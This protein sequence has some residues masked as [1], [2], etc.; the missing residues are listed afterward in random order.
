MTFGFVPE[1]EAPQGRSDSRVTPGLS[2]VSHF[3]LIGS[4]EK[5]VAH[6]VWQLEVLENPLLREDTSSMNLLMFTTPQ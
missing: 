5:V 4:D 3:C 6:Y 2:P 1:Q